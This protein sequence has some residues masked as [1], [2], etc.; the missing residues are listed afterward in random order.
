MDISKILIILLYIGIL[1]L[2]YLSFK[3]SSYVNKMII[4]KL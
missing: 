2:S 3:R 1:I 4:N